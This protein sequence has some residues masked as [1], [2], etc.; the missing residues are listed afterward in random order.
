MKKRISIVKFL[1]GGAIAL[2]ALGG[3]AYAL[4]K[5]GVVN[6][7]ALLES[8]KTKVSDKWQDFTAEVYDIIKENYFEKATDEALSNLF[9]LA[10][11]KT[12]GKPVAMSPLDKNGVEKMISEQ[13]SGMAEDKKKEF[14]LNTAIV[15]LYNLQP[16]GRNGILS[17]K[18]EKEMRDIVNN[19][20]RSRDLYELV[21]IPKNANKETIEKKYNE[22]VAELLKVTSTETAKILEQVRYA[23]N[24]LSD[25]NNKKTY[26]DIGAEPTVFTKE[27]SPTVYYVYLSKVSPTSYDELVAKLNQLEKKEYDSL[28]FDLRGNIGGSV[29]LL[30]Y[31]MGLFIGQGQYAYDFFHQGD[32]KP[33]KTLVTKHPQIGRF[34]NIAILTDKETQSSAELM[35]AI[36]KR[37]N[38]G[39]VIGIATRGWGTIENT[40]PIK[41]QLVSDEKYTLLLVHSIT[42]RD[43]NQPIE[44]RGVEPNISTEDKDWKNQVDEKFGISSP[45]A[46]AIKSSL[47]KPPAKN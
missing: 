39:T 46:K 33:F 14:V 1:I 3:A 21:G 27:I 30:Q 17:Q 36:F 25:E 12:A 16:A 28:V 23:Y 35:V 29:D 11:E 38:V 13:I 24:V 10:A 2:V 43:D 9:R 41:T 22:K 37:Y 45:I 7:A 42:L 32:Y 31:F 19:I 8:E 44:G 40:F 5:T 6:L 20:D 15:V 26:D 34:K 47:A 18:Q 4:E